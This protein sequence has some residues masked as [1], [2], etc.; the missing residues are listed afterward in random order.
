[1][2][3]KEKAN[4]SFAP[5]QKVLCNVV[6]HVCFYDKNVYNKIYIMHDGARHDGCSSV[7]MC[8]NLSTEYNIIYIFIHAYTYV[9]RLAGKKFTCKKVNYYYSN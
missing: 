3:K 4:I 2:Q 9:H 5:E 7:D 8:V 6:L 1:M